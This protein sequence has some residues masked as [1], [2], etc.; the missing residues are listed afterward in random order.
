MFKVPLLNL[1]ATIF[2]GLLLSS[3]NGKKE[4]FDM[5]FSNIKFPKKSNV[6]N[7]NQ[8]NLSSNETKVEVIQ[9]K[10]L[11]YQDKSDIL[12]SVAIGKVDPFSKEGKEVNALTSLQITG[13]LNT[14][15]NKYVFVS[16]KNNKGTL[17]E[18]EIGGINT[19]LLPNG[20]QVIDINEKI[21]KLTINFENKDY[22]FEM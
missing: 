16:Y 10:L 5:D 14:G 12:S 11:K 2:I 6:K 7:L 3:C 15:N 18:G 4:N 21:M 17:T 19:N 9:N 20:A 1:F 22:I 13:F 8:E